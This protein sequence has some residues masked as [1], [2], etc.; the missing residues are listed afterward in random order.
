M[1][2][3]MTCCSFHCYFSHAVIT[4]IITLSL[5][6]A[7]PIFFV[8]TFRCSFRGGGGSRAASSREP[9]VELPRWL[10]VSHC[11]KPCV[12]VLDR[13]STRLNSSHVAIS[14][15]VFGLKQKTNTKATTTNLGTPVG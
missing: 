10:G 15:A 7:L 6:D 3:R 5:H 11:A 1:L 13:K 4:L 8:R 14:Y 12:N 9:P 2:S